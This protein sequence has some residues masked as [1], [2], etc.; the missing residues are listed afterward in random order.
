MSFKFIE[1]NGFCWENSR[2][3][4]KWHSPLIDAN[5]L[6]I[7][8]PVDINSISYVMDAYEI[9]PEHS[10]NP[11]IPARELLFQFGGSGLPMSSYLYDIIGQV[12]SVDAPFTQKWE[13][14]EEYWEVHKYKRLLKKNVTETYYDIYVGEN[15]YGDFKKMIKIE[16]LTDSDLKELVKCCDAFLDYAIK[17]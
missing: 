8:K 16:N 13:R 7:S 17:P 5:R 4:V 6:P 1:N 15:V 14:D 10:I 11:N 9:H 3:G 12:Q 2:I